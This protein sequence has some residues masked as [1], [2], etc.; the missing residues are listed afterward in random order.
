MQNHADRKKK[1]EKDVYVCEMRI[2]KEP[3]LCLVVIC[4]AMAILHAYKIFIETKMIVTTRR[5]YA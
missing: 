2:N 4:I 3:F 1:V 5:T